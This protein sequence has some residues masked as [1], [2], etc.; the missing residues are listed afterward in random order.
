MGSTFDG[1]ERKRNEKITKLEDFKVAYEQA[2]SDAA[3]DF[4]HKF[5]VQ[6]ATVADK[7]TNQKE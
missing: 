5:V 1:L 3:T 2:E 4:S 6:R 7:K